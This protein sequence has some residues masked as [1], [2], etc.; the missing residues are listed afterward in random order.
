[1]MGG[2]GGSQV[3]PQGGPMPHPPV[4]PRQF[5]FSPQN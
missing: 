3:V 5:P 4:D 1:M 2:Q